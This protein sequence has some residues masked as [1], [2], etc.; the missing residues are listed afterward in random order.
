MDLVEVKK[1]LDELSPPKL[2]TELIN[3]YVPFSKEKKYVIGADT[4]EGFG[5]DYCVAQVFDIATREQVAVLRGHLQP[6]DFAHEIFNIASLYQKGASQWPLVAVERNNHG[7]AVLLELRNHIKYKNLYRH[8]D[9]KDGWITDRV[10]RPIMMNAFIDGVE[11]RT[12]KLNH[13]ETLKECLTLV[14][15]NG[16]IQAVDNK[17]DDCVISCAI[18]LQLIIKNSLELYDNIKSKILM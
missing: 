11:N 7:H 14:S 12:I 3:I 9:G 15:K 8:A 6:L 18:A 1:Q 10:T 16:K 17:H 5:G 4:A 13:A 2:S